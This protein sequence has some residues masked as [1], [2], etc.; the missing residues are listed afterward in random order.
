MAS[1][2]QQ[3]PEEPPTKT[4]QQIFDEQIARASGR[5][6]VILGGLGIV[7]ALVMSTIALINSSG[8]TT[9]TTVTAPAGSTPGKTASGGASAPLTADA[10]GKRLFV[11]GDRSTG[12][13]A[14]GSCHT[15]DAAGTSSTIGPNLDTELTADPPSAT[16][17][18]IV[19]PTKEVVP[20]YPA[21]VMPK[22]YG[23]TLT[24]HQLT[25]LVNYVYHSTNTKAI[26][27]A[28]AQQTSGASTSP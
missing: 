11:A 7:A 18:S 6:V 2:E 19:D 23:T 5:G 13:T 15:M 25:A 3:Q 10:L 22:N 28:K 27:K 17:E 1:D 12:A 16:R 26:A 14:C 20:G 9:T 8:N 21:N 24:R 4:D